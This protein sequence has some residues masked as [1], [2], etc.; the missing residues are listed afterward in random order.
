MDTQGWPLN[1]AGST[2]TVFLLTI[3]S[4]KNGLL[5]AGEVSALDSTNVEMVFDNFLTG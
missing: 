5:F 4:D 3:F 2:G 1:G